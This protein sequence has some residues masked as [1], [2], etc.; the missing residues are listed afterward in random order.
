MTDVWSSASQH[1]PY[2][3]SPQSPLILQRLPFMQVIKRNRG[4]SAVAKLVITFERVNRK[5]LYQVGSTVFLVTPRHL[6]PSSRIRGLQPRTRRSPTDSRPPLRKTSTTFPMTHGSSTQ[7]RHTTSPPS[8]RLET[9]E[10]LLLLSAQ[11]TVTSCH[12]MASLTY[13]RDV[14]I[15][16]VLSARLRTTTVCPSQPHTS[17][18]APNSTLRQTVA[19]WGCPQVLVFLSSAV[20]VFTSYT[21]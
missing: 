21:P 20:V 14:S 9:Y 4:A 7:G 1:N 3:L 18:L 10:R 11:Q 5:L 15:S 2:S 19:T 16:N 17:K 13:Q 6:Q 8:A 12:N